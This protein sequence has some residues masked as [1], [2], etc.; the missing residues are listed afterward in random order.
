MLDFTAGEMPHHQEV[1]NAFSSL[2]MKHLWTEKGATGKESW[3]L[4]G[5]HR[6]SLSGLRDWWPWRT[7]SDGILE[8]RVSLR[9]LIWNE[10]GNQKPSAPP[11]LLRLED[12]KITQGQLWPDTEN[13]GQ[14]PESLQPLKMGIISKTWCPFLFCREDHPG[15]R[16]IYG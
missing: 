5:T 12:V 6:W 10:E 1:G 4:S 9:V 14:F 3:E 11:Y 15:R 8:R 7:Y 2:Q 16:W 13:L